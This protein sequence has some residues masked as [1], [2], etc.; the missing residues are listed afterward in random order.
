MRENPFNAVM[1][2]EQIAKD[3][4]D[5]N[6]TAEVVSKE[7]AIATA[8][9]CAVYL[10][11]KNMDEA[12]EIASYILGEEG[13]LTKLFNPSDK[14]HACK[15]AL[16]GQGL[17]VEQKLKNPKQFVTFVKSEVPDILFL[18]EAKLPA[19]AATVRTKISE[20]RELLPEYAIHAIASETI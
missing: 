2:M 7:E 10:I 20:L 17:M 4:V 9:M 12:A 15:L 5:A 13:C 18:Q 6:A 19:E 16:E 1:M 14:F 3:K 8:S 11:I